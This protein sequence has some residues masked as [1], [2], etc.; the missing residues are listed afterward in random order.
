MR[1]KPRI[2]FCRCVY[3]E[4]MPAEVKNSVEKALQAAKIEFETAEDLCGW[5]ARGDERLKE[6]AQ[7]GAVKIAACY[8]RAVRWLFAAAGAALP[9]EGVEIRNMREETAG[10][11]IAALT[12]KQSGAGKCGCISSNIPTTTE[13]TSPDENDAWVPW[14]P[15]ID[16]ERCSRCG[17]CMNFCL[18]GVYEPGGDGKVVVKNPRKCKT[19]CPACARICPEGAIIFPKYEHAPINGGE[20]REAAAE[21]TRVEVSELIKGDIYAALRRRSGKERFAAQTD[22]ERALQEREKC[23]SDCAC[24]GEGNCEG[25]VRCAPD[26][27][28]D[29][30]GRDG[31]K[32]SGE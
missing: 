2:L 27:D 31:E 12:G 26:C 28:C 13:K 18:F 7:G 25:E 30:A 16:Y 14:F 3:A 11:I 10:E 23:A 8:P 6:Y 17:Q 9:G 21:I 5:A 29:C 19:N 24:H 32:S 4:V 20:S 22:G 1:G 15:V